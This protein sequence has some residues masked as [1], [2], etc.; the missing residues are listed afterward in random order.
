MKNIKKVRVVIRKKQRPVNLGLGTSWCITNSE[1]ALSIPDVESCILKV[2]FTFF[3]FIS[4][5]FD[6]TITLN[7]YSNNFKRPDL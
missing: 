3:S 6:Y 5:Q 2:D 1:A 7:D 4:M